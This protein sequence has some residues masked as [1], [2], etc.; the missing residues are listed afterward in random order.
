LP[1]VL[2]DRVVAM[3]YADNGGN[4]IESSAVTELATLVAA[5]S[6]TFQSLI[7]KKKGGDPTKRR[8]SNPA[9]SAVVKQI[10]SAPPISNEDPLR[11]AATVPITDQ[12]TGPV[13]DIE[14][15]LETIVSHRGDEREATEAL[16]KLGARGAK[17]I[18]GK[19]P[20]PLRIDRHDSAARLAPLAEYGP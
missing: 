19:L 14:R 9:L 15:L 17:T 8:S 5:A 4:P 11:G 3:L 1:L 10:A 7:I 13:L 2:R 16:L 12:P 20:G 18:V 6:R